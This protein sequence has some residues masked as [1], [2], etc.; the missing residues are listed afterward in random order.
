MMRKPRFMFL[1]AA[2]LLI[3]AACSSI[4]PAPEGVKDN[5]NEEHPPVQAEIPFLVYRAVDGDSGTAK[6]GTWDLSRSELAYGDDLYS[7]KGDH[8]SP[9]YWSGT[10]LI[11]DRQI[12]VPVSGSDHRYTLQLTDVKQKP[13]EQKD[14]FKGFEVTGPED[15]ENPVY[16]I[17]DQEGS[18]KL[19][20]NDFQ[21]F[22]DRRFYLANA[23]ATKDNSGFRLVFTAA[24]KVFKPGEGWIVVVDYSK[25]SSAFAVKEF[26]ATG[27]PFGDMIVSPGN[28]I[29]DGDHLYVWRSRDFGY[30]D[31]KKE[32]FVTQSAI[33]KDIQDFLPDRKPNPNVDPQIIP[34]GLVGNLLL[35]YDPTLYFDESTSGAVVYAYNG[36]TPAGKLLIKGGQLTV[37]DSNNKQVGEPQTFDYTLTGGERFSFPKVTGDE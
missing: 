26:P 9:L 8:A 35:L 14:V 30:F 37:Y 23:A 22:T 5:N 19:T 36:E 18:Y 29:L 13:E 34:V 7:Y 6:L 4:A 15:E 33:Y 2:L 25:N 1:T 11:L 10:T 24:P 21:G 20:L 32:T 31:L 17:Q 28:S 12:A 16:T 3:L 27:L